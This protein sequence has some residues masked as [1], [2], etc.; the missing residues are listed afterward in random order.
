MKKISSR[1][2]TFL[3]AW[4]A[5]WGVFASVPAFAVGEYNGVWVGVD[6]ISIPGEVPFDETTGTVIYQEN[7]NELFLYDPMLPALRL[8]KSGSDWVLPAPMWVTY[9]G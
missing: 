8:I 7:A 4:V 9:L 5:A 2:I 3:L 1:H 6:T